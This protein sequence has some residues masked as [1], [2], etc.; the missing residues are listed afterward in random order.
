MVVG[1]VFAQSFSLP[2]V[3]TG[4]KTC[5]GKLARSFTFFRRAGAG[6][7]KGHRALDSTKC[8]LAQ[9]RTPLRDALQAKGTTSVMLYVPKKT[10]YQQ[11]LKAGDVFK[12]LEPTV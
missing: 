11:I 4:F 3:L 10:T 8:C 12:V 5:C 1:V 9:L 2:A 6:S 7:P